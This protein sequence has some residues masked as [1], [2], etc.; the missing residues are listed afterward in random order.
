M[1]KW[2]QN[3]ISS[4]VYTLIIVGEVMGILRPV[5]SNNKQE[6]IRCQ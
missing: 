3:Q 4:G 2:I 6:I 1:Q 5:G